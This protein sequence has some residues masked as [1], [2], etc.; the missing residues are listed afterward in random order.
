MLAVAGTAQH[1]Q[2]M[3]AL[4]IARLLCVLGSQLQ[5]QWQW[6]HYRLLAAGTELTRRMRVILYQIFYVLLAAEAAAAAIAATAVATAATVVIAVAMLFF[7][8][9]SLSL[10]FSLS[11]LACVRAV[12]CICFKD[13]FYLQHSLNSL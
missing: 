8:P 4:G 13:L 12:Y 10:Y 7:F 5:W 3:S 6:Q 9:P 11:F 1:E 2:A